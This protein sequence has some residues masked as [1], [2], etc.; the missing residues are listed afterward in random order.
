RM[1]DDEPDLHHLIGL[2]VLVKSR[3]I[4]LRP[5]GLQNLLRNIFVNAY[6]ITDGMGNRFQKL[7]TFLGLHVLSPSIGQNPLVSCETGKHNNH[8]NVR[9]ITQSKTD[10]SWG[11]GTRTDAKYSRW[12]NLTVAMTAHKVKQSG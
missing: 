6:P 4:S 3:H 1:S 10:G 12:D 2:G 9:Q 7:R 8:E 11:L 5:R